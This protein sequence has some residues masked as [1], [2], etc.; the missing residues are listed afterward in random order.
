MMLSRMQDFR[1]NGRGAFMSMACRVP[2]SNRAT[3]GGAKPFTS[4]TVL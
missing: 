2:Q 3:G 4:A 1:L